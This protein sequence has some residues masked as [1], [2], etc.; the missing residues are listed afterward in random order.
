MIKQHGRPRN[1]KI[2]TC[3]CCNDT[4]TVRQDLVDGRVCDNCGSDK[5]MIFPGDYTSTEGIKFVH[6]SEY[7]RN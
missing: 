7:L 3:K 6:D 1:F 5:M 2:L 4:A